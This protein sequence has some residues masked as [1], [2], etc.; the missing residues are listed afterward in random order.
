V[1]GTGVLA[2]YF[3]IEAAE[4]FYHTFSGWLIFVVAFALLLACGAVL[5]KIGLRSQTGRAGG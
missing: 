3:G 5:S 2:H 4:G 1:S